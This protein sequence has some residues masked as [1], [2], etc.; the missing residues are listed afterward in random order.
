MSSI[1]KSILVVE[2]NISNQL[3]IKQ[4]LEMLG[5]DVEIVESGEQA[6]KH[7]A[8]NKFD[9]LMTDKK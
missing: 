8:P 9:I 6:L 3:L 4:Q 5:Y 7:L 2:D 1:I